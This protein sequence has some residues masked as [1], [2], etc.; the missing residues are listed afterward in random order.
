MRGRS[1][2]KPGS[3]EKSQIPIRT[4]ADWDDKRPE[5]VEIDLAGYDGGN[6]AGAV[7]NETLAIV[8]RVGE[9]ADAVRE[10]ARLTV[11]GAVP[12]RSCRRS[13]AASNRIGPALHGLDIAR[14]QGPARQRCRSRR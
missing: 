12:A 9:A 13:S 2:A 1:R 5:S 7:V 3:L 6:A 8:Q 14:A 4:W 10:A 11:R